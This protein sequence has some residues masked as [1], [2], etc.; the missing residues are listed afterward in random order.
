[1]LMRSPR[2]AASPAGGLGDV[3]AGDALAKPV[4]EDVNDRG[5]VQRED[6]AEQQAAD[7]G[8]AQRPAQLRA[9]AGSRRQRN[10]G[11]K[12]GHGGHHDGPEAQQAGFVDRLRRIH[13][14][15]ALGLQRKV[16]DQNAVLVHNADEQNDADDADG[17]QVL[18]AEHKRQQ[19]AHS[20]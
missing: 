5:R 6:L 8:D 20:G 17:V 19:R 15:L 13:A 9:Q 1:M 7:H 18:A 4:K 16:H 14:V 11:Q 2:P 3:A 12:R 10:A